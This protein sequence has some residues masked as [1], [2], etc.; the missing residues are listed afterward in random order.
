MM[1]NALLLRNLGL[2]FSYNAEYSGT[3]DTQAYVARADYKF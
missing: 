1:K 3:Q 2:D